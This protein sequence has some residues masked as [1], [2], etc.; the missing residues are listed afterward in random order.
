VKKIINLQHRVCN[1]TCFSNGL[2]DI[3]LW[4]GADYSL[5]LLPILGGMGEFTYLKIKNLKPAQMVFWGANTKYLFRDLSMI[6]GFK[7]IIFENRAFKKMIDK[8]KE[9]I[10]NEQP[11]IAGALDMFYL[12]YFSHIYHKIHIPIHYV[13]V[14][15]YDDEE[16]VVYVYDC[17]NTNLQKISYTEFEYALNVNVPG[18]SKKNTIRI[19]NLPENLPSEIEI[20]RKGFSYRANKMLHPG[21]KIFGIPAM[22]KLADE[23]VDWKDKEAFEHLVIFATTPPELPL[24]FTKSNG[25]RFWKANVLNELGKKYKIENW[26]KAG[27]LFLKAGDIIINI[28]K[29]AIKQDKKSISEKLLKLAEVEEEAYLYLL[30]E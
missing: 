30:E 13:L 19:I 29:A 23:I 24:D 8:L 27:E 16:E 12:P 6:I 17:S 11:V 14:V 2:E 18:M 25:M 22:R 3:L 28:C 10:N 7:E 1:S 20:A 15:G 21:I 9:A 26:K 5:Y 4:K